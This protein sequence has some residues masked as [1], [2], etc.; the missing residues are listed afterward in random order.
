LKEFQ[1][2]T[3]KLELSSPGKVLRNLLNSLTQKG[4]NLWDNA[5]FVLADVPL[6]GRET[7][8][9]LPL[10]L[11]PSNPPMATLFIADYTKTS[12]TTPYREAAML[13]HARSPLGHGRHCCW[14]AVDDDTALIYGRELLGYPKKM[15]ALEF[16]E[17]EGNIRAAVTRR[18]V[19]VMAMEAR[20]GEP[21][22]HP[23]PVFDYKTFNAGAMGQFFIMSPIWLFRPREVIHESYAAEVKLTLAA[24]DYDP[25]TRLVAGEPRN[26]RIV[27]MDIPGSKYNLPVGIAGLSWFANTFYLRFR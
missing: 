27:V 9:I 12:F 7:K 15:A 1:N 21:Q 11:W 20:R 24:S 6:D 19:K 22:N 25:L 8:K 26:G 23:P 14:M 2:Q 16:D 17:R 5:R 10:G 13:V 18:G 3:E 4:E